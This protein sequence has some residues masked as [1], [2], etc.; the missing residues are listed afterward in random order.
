VAHEFAV[1]APDR[2]TVGLV[3]DDRIETMTAG[4]DG[5]WSVTVPD[6]GPGTDYAFSLDGGDPLPDPRSRWQPH[7]VHAPSRLVEIG[8]SP[9]DAAWTGRS[10]PGSVL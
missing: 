4:A 1:W 3:L 2:T 10:L 8:P 5:W 7:G 6:A 9:A